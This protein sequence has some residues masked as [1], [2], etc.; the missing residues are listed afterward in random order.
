[1]IDGPPISIAS[2]STLC[3]QRVS[4]QKCA[5]M[6]Q[7][8]GCS[9]LACVQASRV[10][11]PRVIVGPQRSQQLASVLE[12]PLPLRGPSALLLSLLWFTVAQP[13]VLES[14]RWELQL[15]AIV[16]LSCRIDPVLTTKKVGVCSPLFPTPTLLARDHTLSP[17][18]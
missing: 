11:R 16:F 14:P 3:R 10:S 15:L 18:H 4:G 17:S 6:R 7:P 8:A 5:V 1:M 13:V 12:P 9:H 2:K